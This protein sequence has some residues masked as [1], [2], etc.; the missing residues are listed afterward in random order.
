MCGIIGIVSRP[1]TRATPDAAE[2][3][4]GLD[5]AVDAICATPTDVVGA[6]V[7]AGAVDQAVRGLPGVLALAG[8]VDLVAALNSRLDRLDA[9]T[10]DIERRLDT[11]ADLL[12]AESLERANA[13]LIDLED[14]LWA[15]RNDRLRTAREV[16]TLAGRDAPPSALGGYLAVQQA[17]S[18]IDRLEV[19][20]RDSAGLHVFVWGHDIEPNALARLVADRG[21]DPLFQSGAV[22]DAGD[23][24]SFVY[25][26]AAEIGELGDNTR[27]VAAGVERR[28]AAAAGAAVAGRA[29]GGPRP[30]PLGER[31]H[32]QRTEHAPAQL[33]RTRTARW[34]AAAVRGGRTER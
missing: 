13:E 16:A 19:R 10:S 29:G 12:D 24:L 20:G 18:A 30:H 27:G 1:P 7:H 31:R 5:R 14:A 22:V 23:C 17:L 9:E 11:N 3:V 32:H 21:T 4:A 33:V 28:R 34:S 25:K 6:T 26:A 2:L 8:H 15:I